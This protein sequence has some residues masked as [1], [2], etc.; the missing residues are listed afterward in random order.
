[1]LLP[2]NCLV[3]NVCLQVAPSMTL[4]PNLRFAA[5]GSTAVTFSTGQLTG[6]MAG[7]RYYFR[8][9]AGYGSYSNGGDGSFSSNNCYDFG[10]TNSTG[11]LE[12]A[13]PLTYGWSATP[14]TTAYSTPGSVTAVLSVYVGDQC[15]N[16]QY[17]PFVAPV[18]QGTAIIQVGSSILKQ[19]QIWVTRVQRKRWPH[20][21]SQMP[22]IAPQLGGAWQAPL[23]TVASHIHNCYLLMLS[24]S[25]V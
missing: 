13:L 16:S 9:D 23:L 25:R 8:L 20:W 18:A 19:A 1:M 11:I 21:A 17:S 12:G 4:T 2:D 24:Q 5:A 10:V 22:S 3:L 14:L 15:W 6:L 7:V